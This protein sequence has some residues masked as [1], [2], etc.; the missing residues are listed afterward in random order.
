MQKDKGVKKMMA[1]KQKYS[2]RFFLIKAVV[3]TPL[4]PGIQKA[5]AGDI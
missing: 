3:G 5:E 2:I 4:I 1:Y